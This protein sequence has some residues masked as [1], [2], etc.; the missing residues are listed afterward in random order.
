MVF[1]KQSGTVLRVKVA[2]YILKLQSE[3]YKT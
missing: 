2:R 3:Q 1:L